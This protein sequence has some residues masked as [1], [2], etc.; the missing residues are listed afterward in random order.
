MCRLLCELTEVLDTKG[1]YRD[2]GRLGNLGNVPRCCPFRELTEML[3]TLELK[4][5]TEVLAINFREL[6]EVL[7]A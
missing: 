4:E 3:A 2:V 5:L 1:T 6:T 7:A